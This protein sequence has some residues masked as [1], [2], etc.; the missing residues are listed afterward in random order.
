MAPDFCLQNQAKTLHIVL[1][2]V[3]KIYSIKSET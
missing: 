3:A 2:K 1:Q